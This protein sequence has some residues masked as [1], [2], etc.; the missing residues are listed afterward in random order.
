MKKILYTAVVAMML[1]SCQNEANDL[2][3]S[4][5]PED[6]VVRIST[7]VNA[8]QTRADG[9]SE[10]TGTDLSLSVDYGTGDKYT[11]HNN[12]WTNASNVW[13]TTEQMLWKSADATAKIYAYAPYVDLGEDGVITAVPFTVAADQSTGLTASDLM[14]FTAENYKPSDNNNAN[15]AI[16]IAFTHKLAKLK[17]ALTFGDQ[18][19]TTPPAIASVTI[20]RTL[21]TTSYNAT[22]ATAGG[23]SGT[24]QNITTYKNGEVYEAIIIPQTVAKDTR[25][26]TIILGSGDRYHYTISATNGHIFAANTEN[27]INLR[28]GKDAVTLA[29]PIQV[30][31]W[32]TGEGSE[33]TDGETE[34]VPPAIGDYYYQDG[35]YKSI[36][37]ND[38]NNPCIGLVYWTDPTNEKHVKIVSLQEPPKDWNGFGNSAGFFEWSTERVATGATDENSGLACMREIMKI[39]NWQRKYPAFAYAHAQNGDNPDYSGS[40]SVWY[41]PAKNELKA[42][43]AG[44]CGLR[45]VASGAGDGEI[46]DWSNNISMPYYTQYSAAKAAFNTKLTDAKGTSLGSWYYLTATEG[47]EN[48]AWC[49]SF[50]S[51]TA[52]SNSKTSYFRVRLIRDIIVP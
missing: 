5:Y 31:D 49:V 38:E 14:G 1:A 51:G 9:T 25:L 3:Q 17:V 41:H 33:L 36:Y 22:T 8:L 26:V 7:Q 10:Y 27:T 6:G 37:I 20:D 28:I 46:N 32:T 42:L 52:F 29:S 35:T 34:L 39:T 24:A 40:S 45:W 4:N 18:F 47:D 13:S 44:W 16:N 12:Q 43:Y 23:A 50:D 48:N 11:V 2:P 21:P 15:K 30:N 19:G